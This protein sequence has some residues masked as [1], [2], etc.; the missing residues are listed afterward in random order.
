[1]KKVLKYTLRSLAVILGLLLLL[2]VGG[3]IYLNQH[4]AEILGYINTESAKR[5]HGQITVGDI[6]ASLFNTF[7]KLSVSLNEVHIQDSLWPQHRHDL[8]YARNAFANIDLFQ[9]ITGH[10]RVSK[11]ILDHALIYVYTDSTG[12]TNTSI[13]KKTNLANK[14]VEEK[15]HYPNLEIRNS[16]VIVEKINKNKFFSFEIPRILC[17]VNTRENEPT[18]DLDINLQA[19]VKSLAFNKEKGS[20][21][22]GKKAKGKFRIQS[23]P[24]SKVLQ[25]EKI[26]IEI[27]RQNFTT[28]GKFFLADVPAL[29]TLSL[30]TE[31]LTYKKAVSFLTE[32]IRTKL[33]QYD[34]SDGINSIICNLDG[35]DSGYR[36]PSIHLSVFAKD[37]NIHTPLA[38]LEKTSFRGSFTNEAIK[39]A[40]HSDENSILHFIALDGVWQDISFHSDSM[41][42]RNLIQ[43]VISCQVKAGFP[44][45]GLDNLIDD[46]TLN[47][48]KGWGNVNLRYTGPLTDNEQVAKDLYGDFI[49]DSAEFTYMP[50]N[51]NLTNGKG[52]I[53]FAGKDMTIEDLHLN[54]GNTDLLLNGTMKNLLSSN[55]KGGLVT[56]DWNIRSNRINLSDFKAFL[57][58]KSGSEPKKKKKVLLS[59]TL[60]KIT[61]LLE[62]DNMQLDLQAKQLNYKKF[63]A[64][65]IRTVMEL[66]EDAINVKDLTLDEAGGTIKAQGS[67]RN[68]IASNPFSFKA[69]FRHVDMSKLLAAFNNFGQNA[70]TDKNIQ[71]SLDASIDLKGEVTEKFQ[72]ISDSTKGQ[73]DFN[74]REGRLVQ[75]E[76][77]QKISQTVF[78]NRNF[79]DIQFADLHDRLSIAG[80]TI[81]INRM[82]IQSSV[83]NMFVEG[84]YNMKKGADLSIQVP[85]SNLSPGDKVPENRGTDSRTGVS[86]VLRA[87]NGDDGKLKITWDPFKKS[88]RKMKKNK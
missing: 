64:T 83:M 20:F 8:L 79:S 41:I 40:G 36:T 62:T 11:V 23:N 37:K 63:A 24:D 43:P 76:P 81:T 33:L 73:V 14:T 67:V 34:I 46:R 25:F 38:D 53:N 70:I 18:L 4:K 82:E 69:T 45:V 74:L 59:E 48:T 28:S 86:A 58:K 39:G 16:N 66:D 26:S 55:G 51:F 31:N 57:K 60:S 22:E 80:K 21:I 61:D 7:P 56:L 42:I 10:I 65:N 50:M 49:M 19:T 78:K 32:N 9:L 29:F 77:V 2:S 15:V 68:Q 75:F 85:L 54:A 84:T 71:G 52:K 12:Y 30:Q 27:D 72:V 44:L 87:K 47:F 6:S 3:W 1:M 17:K 88:V 35:T 13:F 5:M